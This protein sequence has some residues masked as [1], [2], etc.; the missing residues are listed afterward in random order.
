M[1][2]ATIVIVL[3]SA[4][5][6]TSCNNE[7]QQTSKIANLKAPTTKWL[8]SL[9]NPSITQFD[10]I[11]ND[12][13]IQHN[14]NIG[15]GKQE[16]NDYLKIKQ[17]EGLKVDTIRSLQDSNFVFVQSVQSTQYEKPQ[18]VYNLFR[19]VDGHI[20]ENWENRE[21]IQPLNASG[22][23]QIDGRTAITDLDQTQVNKALV[24]RFL[25]TLF[26]KKDLS[27][28]DTFFHDNQYIQH[29]PQ[30]ADGFSSL[31]QVI[32]QLQND[33]INV[34]YDTIHHI[35]GEGNFVLAISE[36]YLGNDKMSYFDLFRID[37]GKIAEH[38]DSIETIPFYKSWKNSNG[39]F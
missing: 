14:L 23:S 30:V 7:A 9:N 15:E 29:N 1:R 18:V 31:K 25:T 35:K 21:A 26:I 8:H 11:S 17:R 34:G 28:V 12:T 33:N 10:L 38:W 36:G 3:I 19:Y 5:G 4:I 13:F 16:Y 2:I 22:R 27:M 39:K 37:N 24:R 20:V 32:T 6:L